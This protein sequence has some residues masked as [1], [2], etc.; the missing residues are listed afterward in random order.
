MKLSHKIYAG[1]ALLIMMMVGLGAY[2]VHSAWRLS[3]HF[4]EY[5][6]AARTNLII[7]GLVADIQK[8]HIAGDNYLM[9]QN[10]DDLATFDKHIQEIIDMD[11]TVHH[12][13]KDSAIHDQLDKLKERSENY[14]ISFKDNVAKGIRDPNTLFAEL[15]S[16]EK[17]YSTIAEAMSAE[18]NRIGPEAERVATSTKQLVPIVTGIS[19]I[20]GLAVAIYIGKLAIST[21]RGVTSVMS[22]LSSGDYSVQIKGQERRD[23]IGE[24]ARAIQKFKDDSERAYLL[25][26]MVQDMPVNVMT[27]DV[28]NDFKIN[29]MNNTSMNTL[30]KLHQYLPVRPEDMMGKSFDMF[31]KNPDHQRRLVGDPKNLPHRA[32]I[33]VG[34][35]TMDLLV[36][37]IKNAN[38]DYVG[39]MLT[40]SIVSHQVKLADDF[41]GSVGTMATQIGA[42]ADGLQK[43]A[44]ILES[45][46]EE[47]SASALEISKRV[48]DSVN[49]VNNATQEAQ[50]TRERM[51]KLADAA[52]KI[53]NV[54]SLIRSIADK[55]NMLSLN[56]TIESARAGDAGKGFA[57]VA[58]E[59]KALADRTTSAIAE[60]TQKVEDMQTSTNES[61]KSVQQITE[62]VQTINHI[63]TT[64]ASAVEQQQAATREIARNISGA[65]D[66]GS[67][68]VITMAS[69]MTSVSTQLQSECD[70]FLDKI[71]K[72]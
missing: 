70:G 65:G 55:I 9:N 48:S 5:R 11:E 68:S 60:I 28:K 49:I 3:E 44:V 62:V 24:M 43:N 35:E 32:R 22:R 2:S 54:I 46:I 40:W 53:S 37:A 47:L 69:Q 21:I 15:N 61:V 8:A 56:A 41:K 16:I 39:A 66:A 64:I 31:H 67:S 59:V 33:K 10:A 45:A 38:D 36:S 52:E 50:Q 1:F 26:Q 27:V 34:T 57:V 30:N 51:D 63:A 29:Y 42:T 23:E 6:D 7:G 19:L 25:K 18:Q 4:D 17:E 20:M 71:A 58:S 72:M 12:T 13:V 14:R